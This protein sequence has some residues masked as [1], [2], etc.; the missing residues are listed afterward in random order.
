MTMLHIWDYN[1]SPALLGA[2]PRYTVAL[3]IFPYSPG[4]SGLFEA[5]HNLPDQ[6]TLVSEVGEPK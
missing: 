5:G 3:P 4:V 2:T 1:T 6:L